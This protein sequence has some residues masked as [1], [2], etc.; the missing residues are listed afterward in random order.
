MNQNQQQNLAVPESDRLAKL[1]LVKTMASSAQLDP[2]AFISTVMK[3]CF[4]V[5]I[6]KEQFLAFL[7]VAN[8]Y[9][10][11]PLTKEIHGFAKGGKVVPIVGIDGWIAM[12]NKRTELDGIEYEDHRNETGGIEAI[13][14]VIYRKDRERPMKVTE[15]LDECRMETST[16]KKW[17]TRM[18][19]HKAT[20]QCAR[21][22][23]GFSGIYDPDEGQRIVSGDSDITGSAQ[24]VDDKP[25]D[26]ASRILSK[27]EHKEESKP[28]VVEASNAEPVVAELE[29]EV[30]TEDGEIINP[31]STPKVDEIP[32][33]TKGSDIKAPSKKKANPR[34]GKKSPHAQTTAEFVKDLEGGGSEG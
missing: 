23:F 17:P 10:L 12:I 9:G 31:E 28:I 25:Y 1:D 18:L 15:Y 33:I 5:E 4:D 29:P 6:T 19:R 3:L 30:V 21:L 8:E 16:W 13:T 32:G 20:I 7:M 22:A 11:N 14:C 24:V 34:D 2:N 26:A 27:I